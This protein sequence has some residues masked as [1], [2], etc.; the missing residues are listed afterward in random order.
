ASYREHA[1]EALQARN[2][3]TARI[4]FER[5]LRLDPTS[6]EFQFGSATVS[7]SLGELDRTAAIMGQLA[8][9]GRPGYG[10]AHL[11][12]AR[13]WLRGPAPAPI[14]THFA[15]IHL[16]RAVEAQ[17]DNLEAHGLLGQLL[18]DKGLLGPAERHLSKAVGQKPELGLALARLHNAQGARDRAVIEAE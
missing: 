18:L 9:T 6:P 17:P 4:A 3:Q 1:Y 12:H 7:E 15:E 11:R 16:Y 5:L 2:F 10:P 8:P 13:H 14:K